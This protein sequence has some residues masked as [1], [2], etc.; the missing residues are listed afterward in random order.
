[1]FTRKNTHV[2]VAAQNCSANS[3]GA[4]TGEV[5]AEQLTDIN[6]PWVILGHSERRTHF[7]ENDDVVAKKVEIA[8]K[9]KLKVIFCFGET[10]AEREA[11]RTIEVIER[12]LN[13]IKEVASGHWQDIV[14]AY[15]P[16]WAIGTGKTATTEQVDEIHNWIRHYL[17]GVHKEAENCRIIYGGSVTD[18]NCEELIKVKNVDGFLV[19]GASLKDAFKTIVQ[20]AALKPKQ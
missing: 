5:T 12:Q 1:M 10:L 17:A 19:G 11:N 13:A 6:V 18:K 3:F 15:E 8:L 7:G 20:S 9:N 4:F 16:V 2:Q 14:L